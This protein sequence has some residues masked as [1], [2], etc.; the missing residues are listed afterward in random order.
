MEPTKTE[1]SKPSLNA[2]REVPFVARAKGAN[3]VI[4]TGDFT[5]WSA[6]GIRL[7]K[8]PHDEWRTVLELEPGEYQYRLL[9]DG[10][11]QDDPQS[12]KK[13]PNPYGGHNS[14]LRVP[15]RGER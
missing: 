13:V 10:S 8:G 9:V 12:S 1:R 7:R 14:I 11:W 5:H 2:T 6:E 3:E 4:V 15:A